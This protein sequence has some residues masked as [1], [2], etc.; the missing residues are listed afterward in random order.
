MNT[1]WYLSR[2]REAGVR[3]V[4][5]DPRYTAPPRRCRGVDTDRAGDRH[6]HDVAMAY[7]MIKENLQDQRFID[8]YSLV[9]II[10]RITFRNGR[11]GAQ[12][13]GVGRNHHRRAG[14]HDSQPG[15]GVRF[16][17]TGGLIR[18]SAAGPAYGEQYHGRPWC[19]LP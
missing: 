15:Q 19:W 4:S 17:E 16:G 6:R 5:V 3:I 9:S 14:S 18:N 13:S 7:V 8:T 2:A 11:W 12:D 10:S 1:A